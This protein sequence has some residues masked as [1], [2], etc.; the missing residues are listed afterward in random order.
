MIN[1]FSIVVWFTG[2]D[3]SNTLTTTDQNNLQTYLDSGGKLFVSGSD[4]GWD[5]G[6]SSF[7][8]DYLHAQYIRDD[9]NLYVLSGTFHSKHKG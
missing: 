8:R 2:D 4:I 1:N 5:I 9:T 6:G 3:W 7:Y